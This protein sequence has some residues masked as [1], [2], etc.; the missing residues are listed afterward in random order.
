V[1]AGP[2]LVASVRFQ[3]ISSAKFCMVVSFCGDTESVHFQTFVK[4]PGCTLTI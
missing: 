4:E 3:S 2:T 1:G